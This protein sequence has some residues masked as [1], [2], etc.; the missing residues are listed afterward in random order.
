ME[1]SFT[2]MLLLSRQLKEKDPNVD[3]SK[4]NP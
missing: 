1:G 4:S 2:W 3:F